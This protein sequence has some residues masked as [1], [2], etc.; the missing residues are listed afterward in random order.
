MKPA[1]F[2]VKHGWKCWYK[3][4]TSFK[5]DRWED[6]DTGDLHTQSMALEIQRQRNWAP[7]LRK[8]KI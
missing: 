6:P 3:T 5:S 8:M 7:K 1:E 4:K 2:L